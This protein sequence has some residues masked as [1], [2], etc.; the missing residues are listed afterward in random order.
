MSE[1]TALALLP[2]KESA[3][4]VFSQDNGLEPYLQSIREK[5]DEFKSDP[6]K[7]TTES[8]RKEYRSFAHKLARMK[9]ALEGMKKDCTAEMKLV[10][11]KIDKEG[12]RSWDLI[13]SWQDEVLEPVIAYENEQKAIEAKRIA[14]EAEAER[15]RLAEIAARE[16]QEQVERDH[17]LAIYQYADY[18]REKDAAAKQKIIND[19][20]A[21]QQQKEREAEIARVAAENAIIEEQRKAEAE[22]QRLKDDQEKKDRENQLEIER[23]QR[24]KL[25]AENEL[26]RQ[27]QKSDDDARIAKEKAEKEKNDAIEAERQSVENERLESICQ[28]QELEK[29]RA[30]VGQKR[31]EAKESLI[32]NCGL[33][34]DVAKAV[35]LAIANDK[36]INVKITY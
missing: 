25:E 12:K 29:N 4:T 23:V 9:T 18:L 36:I 15:V 5:I 6:P 22:K 19:E 24:E 16:L 26:L 7:L 33:S 13:E 17:E 27:K 8:G 30:H 1:N 28:Q 14:D 31:K 10:T 34:E 3:I 35:V 21:A 20:L 2:E 32:L 11:S